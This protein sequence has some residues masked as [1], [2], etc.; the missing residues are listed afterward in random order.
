MTG[1]LAIPPGASADKG[2]LFDAE[3]NRPTDWGSTEQMARQ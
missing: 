1:E 3:W 2:M